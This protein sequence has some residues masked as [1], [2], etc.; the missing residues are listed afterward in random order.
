MSYEQEGIKF[1]VTSADLDDDQHKGVA[2]GAD[3]R[4]ALAAITSGLDFVGVISKVESTGANGRVSVQTR[5]R[6]KVVTGGAVNEGDPLTC[7]AGVF[8][9]ADNT[10][11]V[12]A[13]S[14][15][16]ADSGDIIEV[17]LIMPAI[18]FANL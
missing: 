16:A 12:Y 13:K 15:A 1:F 17:E 4:V 2:T 11:K 10:D 18:N 7:V 8:E 5:G 6:V 9:V 14:N 3:G